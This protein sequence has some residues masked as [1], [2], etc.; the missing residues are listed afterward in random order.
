M[1]QPKV[2]QESIVIKIINQITA[3]IIKLD[4]KTKG[5]QLD[6]SPEEQSEKVP[7]VTRLE[8]ELLRIEA[9]LRVLSKRIRI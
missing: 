2:E 4:E 7:Q 8:S 1:D 6:A 9:Q 5:I 3:E